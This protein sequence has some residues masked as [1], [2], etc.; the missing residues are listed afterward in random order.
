VTTWQRLLNPLHW[1]TVSAEPSGGGEPSMIA[2]GWDEYAKR[3]KAD[4]FPVLPGNRVEHLGDEWTA[5]D[6]SGGGTTY[7]LDEVTIKNFSTCLSEQVLDRYLP[8]HSKQGLEIGPGGGRLTQL[9]LPRTDLLHAADPSETMLTRLTARFKQHPSLRTYVT[10]GM[11]LPRLAEESLDFVASFDVFVHF[12]P[13]LVHWYLRQI[14]RL[15]KPGG[16]GLVHY[17]SVISPIGWR[18]FEADL[19][20]NVEQRT[21]FCAFGTMCPQL[22]EHFLK[23]L[24]LQVVSSDVGFIPRDAIAVF[25]KRTSTV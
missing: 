10:D 14:A 2:R 4:R 12:E 19:E 1:W 20:G 16:I 22:M 6:T 24:D 13:R 7:G 23:A 21:S 25:R 11:T 9:L 18:Q 3:W 5:E 15:L 8:P 17:A